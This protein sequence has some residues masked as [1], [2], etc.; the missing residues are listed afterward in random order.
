VLAKAAVVV[1]ALAVADAVV[2]AVLGVF[3]RLPAGGEFGALFVT[4]L[5]SSLAA[6]GL[7]LLVSSLVSQLSR[8]MVGAAAVGF[9]QVLFAGAFLPV[10]AMFLVGRWLS[11]V[12]PDRWAFDAFGHSMDVPAAWASSGSALGP[13]LLATFGAGFNRPVWN[14]WLILAGFVCLFFAA[15]IMA[16]ARRTGVVRSRAGRR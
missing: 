8:A 12:M 2:L 16:V 11:Y 3:G 6:A 5:L 13:P 4:L 9:P 1:P 14:D 10:P 7:G 15:T